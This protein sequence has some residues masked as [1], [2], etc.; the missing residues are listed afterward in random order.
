MRRR[1]SL[2][3]KSEFDR[4]AENPRESMTALTSRGGIP[5]ME[6]EARPPRTHNPETRRA[7]LAL[8]FCP[9]QSL[10]LEELRA[11]LTTIHSLLMPEQQDSAPA[12]GARSDPRF[13]HKS[14]CLT[15]ERGELANALETLIELAASAETL[16]EGLWTKVR[17]WIVRALKHEEGEDLILITSVN[18]DLGAG[19]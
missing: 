17:H 13:Q 19:D 14:H 5:H 16:D 11:R 6:V 12:E 3:P 2:I 4:E 15:Q 7:L 1:S 9:A 10:G 18:Q 8:G